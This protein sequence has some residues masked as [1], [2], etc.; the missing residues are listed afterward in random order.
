MLGEHDYVGSH[1]VQASG[2]D[3]AVGG[4]KPLMDEAGTGLFYCDLHP[5]Y[6]R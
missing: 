1:V 4:G 2:V 6:S 5:W 3:L